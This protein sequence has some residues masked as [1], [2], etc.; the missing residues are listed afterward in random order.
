MRHLLW[1]GLV[2]AALASACNRDRPEGAEAVDRSGR[3]GRV[4][5]N[6]GRGTVDAVKSVGH[7]V[8]YG[9][10][11][12]GQTLSGTQGIPEAER[13]SQHARERMEQRARQADQAFDTMA[14]NI[15]GRRP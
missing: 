1:T 11:E 13:R 8:V 9:V 2:A 4:V 14:E 10:R 15:R 5:E 6:F 3:A 7:G 12:F